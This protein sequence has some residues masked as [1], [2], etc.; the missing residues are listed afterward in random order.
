LIP[1]HVIKWAAAEVERQHDT[2][3][4]V[5]HMCN[6]WHYAYENMGTRPTLYQASIVAYL[7][8]PEANTIGPHDHNY[9]RVAVTVGHDLPPAW[10]DVPEAMERLWQNMPQEYMVSCTGKGLSIS[11]VDQFI[12]ALLKIHPW[13]D[14]NG[15]TASI[16]WNWMKKTLDYPKPLPDFFGG[17]QS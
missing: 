5:G 10:Y 12:F 4:H 6:A 9:R 17:I 11:M 15:R 13:V 14:G 16:I 1:I 2:P 3:T 7:V 8:K